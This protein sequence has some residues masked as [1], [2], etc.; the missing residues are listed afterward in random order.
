MRPNSVTSAGHVQLFS[1]SSCHREV[2]AG[3]KCCSGKIEATSHTNIHPEKNVQ[4]YPFVVCVACSLQ[5]EGLAS[6]QACPLPLSFLWLMHRAF[7]LVFCS[8]E[9]LIGALPTVGSHQLLPGEKNS[10]S[11]QCFSTI[12]LVVLL[13]VKRSTQCSITLLLFLYVPVNC[14][15]LPNTH[16]STS[17]FSKSTQAA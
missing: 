1:P 15:C 8:S 13:S 2:Y 14:W 9:V 6:R 5:V 12:S 3:L 4:T 10:S 7:L 17:S 16:F 11:Q